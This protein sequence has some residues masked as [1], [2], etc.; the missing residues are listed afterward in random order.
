MSRMPL[1]AL[2]L[3]LAL[4]LLPAT[5]PQA[6]AQPNTCSNRVF[7]DSVYQI[8]LGG[9]RY[10]YKLQVRNGTPSPISV[11]IN[12]GTMYPNITPISPQITGINLPANGSQTVDWASGTNN[13]VSSRTISVVYDAPAVGGSPTISVTNCR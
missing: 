2:A 1:A 9:N 10:A 13:D 5:I 12:I 4:P 11:Q 3:G 6:E 7:V 8:G